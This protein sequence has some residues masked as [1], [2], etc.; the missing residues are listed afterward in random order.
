MAGDLRMTSEPTL[1]GFVARVQAKSDAS[2]AEH[3]YADAV[4]RFIAKV[5]AEAIKE[6]ESE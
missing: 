6:K 4:E 5:V 1:R 2:F 3:K